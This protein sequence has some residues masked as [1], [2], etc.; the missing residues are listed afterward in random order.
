MSPHDPSEFVRFGG[1]V[2]HYRLKFYA[3]I[4]LNPVYRPEVERDCQRLGIEASIIN[5][6]RLNQAHTA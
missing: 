6:G 4:L 3:I 5:L 1:V 2:R